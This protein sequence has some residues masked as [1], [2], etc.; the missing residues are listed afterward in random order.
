MYN[1]SLVGPIINFIMVTTNLS[2]I[3]KK[4]TDILLQ[5]VNVVIVS[6]KQQRNVLEC[7]MNVSKYYFEILVKEYSVQSIIVVSIIT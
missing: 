5:I 6:K 7:Q 2:N 3:R 1:F 4:G